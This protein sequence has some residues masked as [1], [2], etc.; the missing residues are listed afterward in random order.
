METTSGTI[1][2]RA[3]RLG[4]GAGSIEGGVIGVC[5]GKAIGGW[6]STYESLLNL[7]NEGKGDPYKYGKGRRCNMKRKHI[8]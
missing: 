7:E 1:A 4:T 5:V 6:V 3:F 2:G 8:E